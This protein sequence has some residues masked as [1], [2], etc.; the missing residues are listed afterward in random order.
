MGYS[1]NRARLTSWAGIL[2]LL[3]LILPPPVSAGEGEDRLSAF[4]RETQTLKAQFRQKVEGPAG[5]VQE[6]SGGTVWIQRPDHFRWD[7]KRPYEQLIVADGRTVKFFDPQMEQ[8]TVRSYRGGMGHTPSR[9]LAGGGELG[10]HFYVRD[11]GVTEGLAWVALEPRNPKSAGFRKAR[12][13]LA[14]NPVQVRRLQFTDSFG[15]RTRI[16]F[17]DI[18]LNPDLKAERFHFEAPAGTDVLRSGGST[19]P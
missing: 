2:G 11:Q 1:A 12:V 10:E 15:N 7:Y 14:E 17:V 8:V 16:R 3:G 13:G 5:K 9:V 19:N 4:Y 6:R 18:R